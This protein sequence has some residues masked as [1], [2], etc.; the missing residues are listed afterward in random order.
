MV[1][2]KINVANK[3]ME[4]VHR[5]KYLGNW[6]LQNAMVT[7]YTI[8]LTF[9]NFAISQKSVFMRTSYDIQMQRFL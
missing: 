8:D 6:T 1:R 3:P 5:L 4:Q 7:M 2:Y 9:K